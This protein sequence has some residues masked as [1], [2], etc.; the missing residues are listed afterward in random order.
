MAIDISARLRPVHLIMRLFIK[1]PTRISCQQN[2]LPDQIIFW[3]YRY[4]NIGA[5]IIATKIIAAKISKTTK[6][7]KSLSNSSS[8]CRF[9]QP[10]YSQDR[11]RSAVAL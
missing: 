11:V 1:H 9:L 10:F 5:K 2:Y 6:S 3:R 4:Q 8:F 7:S